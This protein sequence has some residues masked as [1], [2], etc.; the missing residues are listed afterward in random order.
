M[1]LGPAW[2]PSLPVSDALKSLPSSESAET[3]RPLVSWT[4]SIAMSG[5]APVTGAFALVDW[6]AWVASGCDSLGRFILLD[7]P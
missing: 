4:S 5:V 6:V 7:L 1:S 3:I 2:S